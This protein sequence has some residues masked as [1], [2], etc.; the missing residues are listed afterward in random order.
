MPRRLP[1]MGTRAVHVTAPCSFLTEASC[2]LLWRRLYSAYT[3]NP[4]PNQMS[5]RNQVIGGRLAM[6]PTD[7]KIP[8]I[9][10]SG[11]RGVLNGRGKFGRLFR[12]AQ[13]P[14][15][16]ITKASSVPMLTR[17]AS[18]PIGIS[19][20]NAATQTPTT[21]EEIHGVRKRA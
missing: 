2:T 6:A 3:S 12:K 15:E 8:R 21:S 18:S 16:T 17:S 7:V 14:A 19:D 4:I 13:T 11:T 5:R 20:A 10:T 9:G 1:Q